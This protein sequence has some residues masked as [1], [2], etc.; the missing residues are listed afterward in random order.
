VIERSGGSPGIR[1]HAG[2]ES[3]VAQP[4]QA[5]AGAD[6]Y[7][8]AAAKAA[9]LGFFITANHAFVDGN[10]RVAHAAMEVMLLLN[11][12]ELDADIDEQER[13]MLRLAA[14][15]CS[16]DEFTEWVELHVRRSGA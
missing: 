6:L 13:A 2:L 1:D 16:R 8:G 11:G 7:V 5:F 10:K 4:R 15:E 14:G 3:A 12:F 9:A